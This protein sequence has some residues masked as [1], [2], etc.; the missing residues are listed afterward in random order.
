MALILSWITSWLINLDSYI[1]IWAWWRS[2]SWNVFTWKSIFNPDTHPNIFGLLVWIF[3]FQFS[4][5]YFSL[6]TCRKFPISYFGKWSVP[7][8]AYVLIHALVQY[9]KNVFL[10]EVKFCRE[11]F[12]SL[13]RKLFP[14]GLFDFHGDWDPRDCWDDD[15]EWPLLYFDAVNDT[16]CPPFCFCNEG[17]FERTFVTVTHTTRSICF[18]GL[19]LCLSSSYHVLA[20][21]LAKKFFGI[22]F[23]KRGL[24]FKITFGLRFF[25]SQSYQYIQTSAVEHKIECLSS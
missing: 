7:K 25:C 15:A 9:P 10:V 23:E 18:L 13:L 14:N 11:R 2:I 20:K 21:W 8:H 24:V 16:N 3:E 4:K 22:L 5:R 6:P 19:F 17:L 1:D 12:L